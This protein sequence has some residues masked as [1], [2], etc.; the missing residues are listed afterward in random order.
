MVTKQHV[1]I[2]LVIITSF[3]GGVLYGDSYG[4]RLP[5]Q[6]QG[7]KTHASISSC[8]FTEWEY[9]ACSTCPRGYSPVS[10]IGGQIVGFRCDGSRRVHYLR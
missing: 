1:I 6:G 2:G 9:Q 8:D 10:I 5:G 4:Y 7:L 3:I